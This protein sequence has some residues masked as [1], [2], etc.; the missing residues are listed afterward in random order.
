MHCFA[1][2]TKVSAA[3]EFL[4]CPGDSS[5]G[6]SG[7]ISRCSQTRRNRSNH[8]VPCVDVFSVPGPASPPQADEH[9][10]VHYQLRP[11]WRCCT[12]VT[13]CTREMG[14]LWRERCICTGRHLTQTLPGVTCWCNVVIY[15]CVC[16]E[17][18]FLC[19]TDVTRSL[20]P[21]VCRIEVVLGPL[22]L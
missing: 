6:P 19:A 2:A 8:F 14:A 21:T 20:R 5:A 18:V 11:S 7:N 13:A 16:Y 9:L 10:F 17:A 4:S 22:R 3:Q 1:R 12:D 15:Q